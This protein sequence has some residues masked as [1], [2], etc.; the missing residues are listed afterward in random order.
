MIIGQRGNVTRL[1]TRRQPHHHRD[2]HIFHRA[3]ILILHHN[4]NDLRPTGRH[5][6]PAHEGTRLQA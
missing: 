2:L 1:F 5:D 4:V 3:Q 6:R